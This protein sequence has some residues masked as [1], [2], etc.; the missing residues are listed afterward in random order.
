MVNFARHVNLT[1]DPTGRSNADKAPWIFVGGS[2]AGSLV[3]WT[4]IVAPGTFWA[5]HSS[6]APLQAIT[7]F[8][9]KLG[10]IS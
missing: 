9:S 6:S 10:L 2:Y 7:D 5:Y 3:A 8:V 1:F 4:D